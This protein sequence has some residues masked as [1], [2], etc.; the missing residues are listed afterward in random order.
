MVDLKERLIQRIKET[1]DD[2]VLREVYRLLEI[3]FDEQHPYKLSNEQ[4]LIIDKSRE[5]IANGNSLT[6]EQ[7][8]KATEQWLNDK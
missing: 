4:R 7:S 3:D 5:E 1:S 8:N 6:H 2:N